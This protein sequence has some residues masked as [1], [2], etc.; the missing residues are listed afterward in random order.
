MK[1]KEEILNHLETVGYGQYAQAKILGYMIGAGLKEESEQIRL[2]YGI[3]EWTHF[4]NWLNSNEEDCNG[5]I[6]CEWLNEIAKE[7]EKEEDPQKVQ[8]LHER[9]ELLLDIFEEE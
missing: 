3:L 6:I 2:A 1:T 4:W 8:K 5:C 9:Y 7:M